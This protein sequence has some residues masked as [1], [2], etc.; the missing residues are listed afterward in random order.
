M[1]AKGGNT[2]QI[3]GMPVSVDWANKLY[4]ACKDDLFCFGTDMTWTAGIPGFWS[5][6]T[7]NPDGSTN[8]N[9]AGKK[10]GGCYNVN[11]GCRKFSAI[12]ANGSIA[13]QQ[14]WHSGGHDAFVIVGAD[15]PHIKMEGPPMNS[16]TNKPLANP[17][18][19]L[20]GNFKGGKWPEKSDK[21]GVTCKS[22]HEGYQCHLVNSHT[23]DVSKPVP[24]LA[25][26]SSG[27]GPGLCAQYQDNACC[28]AKTAGNLH[29]LYGSEKWAPDRCQKLSPACEA[30][31]VEEN[32][33][34]ECDVN[35]GR[36]R[37]HEVECG[38]GMTAKGGN[39]WQ[40]SGMPVSGC[41]SRLRS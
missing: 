2:W 15:K 9:W 6:N 10:L 34:Y 26:N 37:H 38:G 28:S 29:D 32:C 41:L 3:S 11:T 31:F 16:K 39:T 35:W 12:Y 40:I 1:T 30:A 18:D 36:Y 19:K 27:D 4:S 17:N 23:H 22:P 33:G 7:S 8:A 20:T 25:K 13:T 24:A 5:V 21:G 14:F